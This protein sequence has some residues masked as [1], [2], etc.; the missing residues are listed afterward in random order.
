MHDTHICSTALYAIKCIYT[1]SNTW[2]RSSR[3][4]W[5]PVNGTLSQSVVVTSSRMAVTAASWT[6]RK[7]HG[8]SC[9]Q[10]GGRYHVRGGC[11]GDGDGW[12]ST[13]AGQ[14]GHCRATAT[15]V[16]PSIL[17]LGQS[18]RRYFQSLTLWPW[19]WV[20]WTA[21]LRWPG[22]YLSPSTACPPELSN[23]GTQGHSSS[24]LVST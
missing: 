17:Q 7:T 3:R 23:S 8:W 9:Q 15:V 6:A 13:S 4:C 10:A 2:S 21:W 1:L 24:G 20:S 12:S 5:W 14:S 16:E 22:T 19:L 11:W 18:S